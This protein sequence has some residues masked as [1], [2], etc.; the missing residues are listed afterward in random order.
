MKKDRLKYGLNRLSTTRVG[1]KFTGR[2]I[3]QLRMHYRIKVLTI[4]LPL[5]PIYRSNPSR[6]SI[7]MPG[8]PGIFPLL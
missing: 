6:E 2:W 5:N 7:Y 1:G 3:R 4:A 8:L